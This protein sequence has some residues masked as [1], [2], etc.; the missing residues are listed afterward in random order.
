M[1]KMLAIDIDGTLIDFEQQNITS[2]V[3]DAV[4]KAKEKGVYVV[5]ISGRNYYSMKRYLED[6]EIE[7]YGITTNGGLVLDLKT[8][9]RIIENDLDRE[10]AIDVLKEIE[11]N[12]V[13]YSI[14]AGLH[15]YA[16]HKHR[17]D[18]TI[19]FL[20]KEKD[21]VKY[22]ESGMTFVEENTINKYMFVGKDRVLDAMHKTITSKH[23]DDVNVEYG[24]EHHMEVYPKSMNKGIALRGLADELDIDMK[25]VMAIGD[26][27]NDISMLKAAGIGVAMGNAIKEVKDYADYVTKGIAE[28]GVAHAIEKYIL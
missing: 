24:F 7:E 12:Q 13:S 5:L 16:P 3:K 10:I 9:K 22:I 18:P 6:L 8:K 27:E 23:G 25:H 15:I 26:A 2:K 1:V 4:F 11:K 20:A 17:E 19:K 28:D 14:F 21:N